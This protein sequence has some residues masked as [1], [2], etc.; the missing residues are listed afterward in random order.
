[1]KNLIA[2]TVKVN[3]KE[4]TAIGCQVSKREA[5]AAG[6]EC[7]NKDAYCVCVS[8]F[9]GYGYDFND[10]LSAVSSKIYDVQNRMNKMCAA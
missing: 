8:G 2:K 7:G 10:A 9:T 4:T 3:G 6:F 1:M 5:K